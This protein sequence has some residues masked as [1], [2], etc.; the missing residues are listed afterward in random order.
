MTEQDPGTFRYDVYC[1]VDVGKSEHHAC[2]LNPAGKRL[3]DKA[4]PNDEDALK[5]V[6]GKLQTRVNGSSILALA[7]FW[8]TRDSE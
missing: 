6:L 5:G 3:H 4:L 1:G 2:A 8:W 7:H